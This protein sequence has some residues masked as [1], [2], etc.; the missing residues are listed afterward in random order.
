MSEK[1]WW[2]AKHTSLFKCWTHS[3]INLSTGFWLALLLEKLRLMADLRNISSIDRCPLLL[4][5]VYVEWKSRPEKCVF[6]REKKKTNLIRNRKAF[7]RLIMVK[8]NVFNNSR[9][10][11]HK[12]TISKYEAVQNVTPIKHVL[13]TQNKTDPEEI[14]QTYKSKHILKHLQISPTLN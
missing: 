7:S 12:T 3:L 10:H 4:T 2:G 5:A 14:I 1:G 6:N 11:K 8:H 9:Q 13:K